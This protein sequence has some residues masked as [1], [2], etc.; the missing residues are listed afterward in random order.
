MLRL[1][2]ETDMHMIFNGFGCVMLRPR[3][4]FI[5]PFPLV[6][7]HVHISIRSGVAFFEALYAVHIILTIDADDSPVFV[8]YTC[9]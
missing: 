8:A 2:F 6:R 5:I 7:H 3:A 1:D 4:R 9:R